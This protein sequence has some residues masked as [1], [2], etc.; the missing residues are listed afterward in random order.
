ME[1]KDILDID[2]GFEDEQLT[3]Y[4]ENIKGKN[5]DDFN[6]MSATKTVN[7]NENL[8]LNQRASY[9]AAPSIRTSPLKG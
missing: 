3:L 1:M 9:T 4:L 8:S 7:I 6:L 2:M 5:E